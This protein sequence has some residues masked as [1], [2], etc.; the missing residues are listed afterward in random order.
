MSELPAEL[1]L[2]LE[3]AQSAQHSLLVRLRALGLLAQTIDQAFTGSSSSLFSPST[4]TQA[5]LARQRTLTTTEVTAIFTQISQILHD[6]IIPLLAQHQIR[7]S[8]VEL[9]ADAAREWLQGYFN[10]RIYPLLTPLAVDP[11]HPFPYISSDSLN[12]LVL[13]Q[14]GNSPG[15]GSGLLYARVKVPRYAVPRLVF[16]P[17]LDPVVPSQPTVRHLIWSADIVRYFSPHLF[18]GMTV[19]GLYQ[20]HLLRATYHC[21]SDV[22]AIQVKQQKFAPVARLDIEE[23]IPQWLV[24][25]LLEHLDVST[26]MVVRCPIPLSIASLSDLADCVALVLGDS[27][28]RAD[29]NSSS[30]APQ[31]A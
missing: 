31:M 17:S 11:G 13:L 28:S 26:E 18:P 25:W 7:I 27:S 22:G 14:T 12:Y 16:L 15:V 21:A 5:M 29:S 19:T 1:A 24:R 4:V 30:Q 10:H 20:F 6:E 9:L 2:C 8:P 3:T 23:R